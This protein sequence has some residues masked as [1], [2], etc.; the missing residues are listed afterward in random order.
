MIELPQTADLLG[1]LARNAARGERERHGAQGE[2]AVE[3]AQLWIERFQRDDVPSDR[4]EIA[5]RDRSRHG[6]RRAGMRHSIGRA[7]QER[8]QRRE[9]V[10][11]RDADAPPD[12]DALGEERAHERSGV[13]RAGVVRGTRAR[14]NDEQP[15]AQRRHHVFQDGQ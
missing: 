14:R 11:R 12:L 10:L 4:L 2:R 1:A 5:A 8:Q 7:A 13:V 6:A 15:P 3:L 9:R